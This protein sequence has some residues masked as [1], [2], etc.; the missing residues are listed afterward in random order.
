[1]SANSWTALRSSLC[2]SGLALLMLAG[3]SPTSAPTSPPTSTPT[4]PPGA[5]TPASSVENAGDG[6][7]ADVALA[8]WRD[9]GVKLQV[10]NGQLTRADFS[11]AGSDVQ[12]TVVDLSALQQFSQL[13]VLVLAGAELSDVD[14]ALLSQLPALRD[15]TLKCPSVTDAGLAALAD[16]T[17]LTALRIDE[18]QVTDNGLSSLSQL[19]NLVSLKLSSAGI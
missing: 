11:T 14:L 1:M 15:L 4:S 7:A 6:A 18:G 13:K 3:C 16:C 8:D 17:R 10:D 19:D 12:A 2:I 9:R 5:D